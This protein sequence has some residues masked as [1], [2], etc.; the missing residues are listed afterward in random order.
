M[1]CGTPYFWSTS[2]DDLFTTALAGAASSSVFGVLRGS[3]TPEDVQDYI[4]AVTPG[5]V[6]SP[7]ED[8][9]LWQLRADGSIVAIA[10]Q[11][12]P[13]GI[14]QSIERY[15]ASPVYESGPILNCAPAPGNPVHVVVTVEGV[16]GDV[17]P[18][19]WGHGTTPTGEPLT[20]RLVVSVLG[21]QW[22]GAITDFYEARLGMNV[23]VAGTRLPNCLI[24][25]TTASVS[26]GTPLGAPSDVRVDFV[27][28]TI[29][30]RDNSIGEEGFSIT[31]ELA[32]G[33]KGSMIVPPDTT[34]FIVAG[35]GPRTGCGYTKIEIVAFN[36]A[37]ESHSGGYG[38]VADCFQLEPATTPSTSVIA[39]PE[40][41][42]G[43]SP[44]PRWPAFAALSAVIM[45]SA[46]MLTA[47]ASRC[48]RPRR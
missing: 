35:V 20:E 9:S 4:V 10:D 21:T 32:Q 17:N 39:L 19:F 12:A 47:A 7:T 43:S 25:A 45:L 42:T 6:A 41:G 23:E 40:T 3:I 13:A 30:W 33:P 22:E 18:H 16:Y 24:R 11:C 26:Q 31:Y 48:D 1:S 38:V 34:S 28:G 36:S 46:A 2:A 14:V 37:G 8:G 44:T 29:T 27:T 15:F 5:E